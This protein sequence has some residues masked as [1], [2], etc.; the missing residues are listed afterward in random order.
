MMA[1]WLKHFALA[2]TATYGVLL[3]VAISQP[4]HMSLVVGQFGLGKI[5]RIACIVVG[6]AWASSYAIWRYARA[7]DVH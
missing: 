6:V 7:R 4:E 3:V 2:A 5:G 1:L